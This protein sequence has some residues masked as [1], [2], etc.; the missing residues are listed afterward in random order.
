M[1]LKKTFLQRIIK[2]FKKIIQ[3][4]NKKKK[5]PKSLK[6]IKIFILE[7]MKKVL[8]FGKNSIFL[9]IKKKIVKICNITKLLKFCD[10]W[11]IKI[12]EEVI[13]NIIFEKTQ[14]LFVFEKIRVLKKPFFLQDFWDFQH[15]DS[16]TTYPPLWWKS[17]TFN[18]LIET[19]SKNMKSYILEKPKKCKKIA[20]NGNIFKFSKKS[21]ISGKNR[22]RL[23]D[24]NLGFFLVRR[25]S[26]NTLI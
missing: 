16:P 7:K 2:S 3:P 8:I 13:K 5:N 23:D 24:L 4:K 6:K 20:K 21:F 25:L 12:C 14:K 18:V 11:K 9:E 1:K 10:K 22:S 26:H 19:K 15:S 17:S